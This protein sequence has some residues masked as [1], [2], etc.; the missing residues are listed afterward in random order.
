MIEDAK[1]AK[2]TGETMFNTTLERKR[3]AADMAVI[4]PIAQDHRERIRQQEEIANKITN[5]ITPQMA[6]EQAKAQAAQQQQQQLMG[7]LVGMH[8]PEQK[9]GQMGI[10]DILSAGIAALFGGAQGVNQAIE[11]GYQRAGQDAQM[12]FQNEGRQFEQDQ[13]NI[14]LQL[15]QLGLD[16]KTAQHAFDVLQGR[17]W[18]IQD[19]GAKS[20]EAEKARELKLTLEQMKQE[21]KL[22]LKAVDAY[23]TVFG[24]VAPAARGQVMAQMMAAAGGQVPPELLQA[25]NEL[26]TA[27]ALQEA[28]RAFVEGPK[29]EGQ[30]LKNESQR[31]INEYAPRV[32]QSKLDS[33]ESRRYLNEASRLFIDEKRRQYPNY[34][35]ALMG[36]MTVQNAAAFNGINNSNFDREAKEFE[37]KFGR[38]LDA[39]DKRVIAIDSELAKLQPDADAAMEKWN[40]NPSDRATFDTVAGINSRIKAL[41]EEKAAKEARRTKINT[42]AGA[43]I[44]LDGQQLGLTP[45]GGTPPAGMLPGVIGPGGTV[46]TPPRVSGSPG[47]AAPAK[48]K[49]Q[50]AKAKAKVTS[51]GDWKVEVER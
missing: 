19:Q 34:L 50:P 25:V 14:M 11:G 18:D 20:A 48:K 9:R 16:E 42:R 22:D 17:Q 49:T 38:E 21:G 35:A 31:I 46:V 47:K 45:N 39:I 12:Q 1:L 26:T 2:N 3:R 37:L 41:K 6:D 10:A 24:K 44:P 36:R 27:E 30:V 5:V 15:Q 51:R 43:F 28:N 33:E 8:A 4:D 32:I 40:A 29:T 7:Q 23:R 13:Q